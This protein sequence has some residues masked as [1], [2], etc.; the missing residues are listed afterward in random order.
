MKKLWSTFSWSYARH[1]CVHNKDLCKKDIASST[2]CNKIAARADNKTIAQ[3]VAF[4]KKEINNLI[5]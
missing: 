5:S 3:P 4:K 2:L 1:A